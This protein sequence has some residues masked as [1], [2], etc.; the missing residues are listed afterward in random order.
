VVIYYIIGKDELSWSWTPIL[1]IPSARQDDMDLVAGVV[2]MGL[3]VVARQC[4]GRQDCCR[5]FYGGTGPNF[6]R[7]HK[8][9]LLGLR[10]VEHTKLRSHTS[11]VVGRSLA[12]SLIVPRL[13]RAAAA[14]DVRWLR[15]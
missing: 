12:R 14:Q 15:R 13:R 6:C 4:T 5:G 9:G 10:P 1:G 11:I 2:V 7:F 8:R 3:C